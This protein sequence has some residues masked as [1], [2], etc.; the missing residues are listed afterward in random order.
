MFYRFSHAELILAA[1]VL[2][3]FGGAGL[4]AVEASKKA[5]GALAI[6]F[7]AR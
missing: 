7:P 4:V 3:T 5:G 1:C 2:L 6:L